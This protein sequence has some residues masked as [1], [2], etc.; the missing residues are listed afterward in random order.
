MKLSVRESTLFTARTPCCSPPRSSRTLLVPTRSLS[1]TTS[2][3]LRRTRSSTSAPA[4]VAATSGHFKVR[5]LGEV[6]PALLSALRR[7]Q[8]QHS[9]EHRVF[10]GGLE[11]PAASRLA[12]SSI[13]S[14]PPPNS[15]Q[16]R[17]TY[18]RA[19][20]PDSHVQTNGIDGPYRARRVGSFLEGGRGRKRRCGSIGE[21]EGRRERGGGA[22][23]YT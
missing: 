5:T 20:R 10:I 15:K 14:S 12:H 4:Q 3:Q 11:L 21:G 1:K 7:V 2:I 19:L 6:R 16:T 22:A 17:C 9:Q 8:K 23:G 13:S 18:S